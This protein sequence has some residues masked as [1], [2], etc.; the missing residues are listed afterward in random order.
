MLGDCEL[1]L[2]EG[3]ALGRVSSTWQG[4]ARFHWVLRHWLV[5]V[6]RQFPEADVAIAHMH[7]QVLDPHVLA[8]ARLALDACFLRS[9]G[10]G[11]ADFR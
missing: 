10:S 4:C 2:Q 5:Q 8:A 11:N 3:A 1:R 7:L 6:G 9:P